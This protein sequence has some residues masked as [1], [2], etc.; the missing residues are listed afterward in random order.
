MP[1]GGSGLSRTQRQ[2]IRR[3]V[4][5][6]RGASGIGKRSL[7]CVRIVPIGCLIDREVGATPLIAFRDFV[8]TL[9]AGGSRRCGG[10]EFTFTAAGALPAA[11]VLILAATERPS[12]AVCSALCRACTEADMRAAA[13]RAA[14]RACGDEFRVIDPAHIPAA[15]GRA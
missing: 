7:L 12:A 10:C 9:A 2:L 13:E 5:E 8:E 11:L 6:A 15:G 1:D 14:R 3:L 4:R